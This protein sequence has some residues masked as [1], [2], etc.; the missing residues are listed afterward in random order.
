MLPTTPEFYC[1][2][3]VVFLTFWLLRRNRTASLL[4]ILQGFSLHMSSV[5][6]S[7]PV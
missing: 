6:A 2:L 1:F 4:L 7:L 5:S 3:A